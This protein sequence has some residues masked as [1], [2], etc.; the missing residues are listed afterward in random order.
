MAS[1]AALTTSRNRP[2]V[3]TI[4][5]RLRRRKRGPRMRLTN[6]KI[7]AIHTYHPNP[8]YTWMPETTFATMAMMTARISN[9]ASRRI[10]MGPNR[11]RLRNQSGHRYDNDRE[12]PNHRP[13]P[14]QVRALLTD[15]QLLMQSMAPAARIELELVQRSVS[16]QVFPARAR[17]RSGS[18][19]RCVI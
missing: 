4:N 16:E 7:K 11:I 9:L 5:G 10:N 13:S 15:A 18:I 17:A 8:P 6:E 3:R 19:G 2:R 12:A 1:N 14:D